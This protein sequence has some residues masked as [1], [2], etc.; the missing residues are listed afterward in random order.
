MWE[1]IIRIME[2][3]L[4]STESKSGS[5]AS[6]SGATAKES[7][8]ATVA[9]S[10]SEE[11]FPLEWFGFREIYVQYIAGK[12]HALTE[13]GAFLYTH[14]DRHEFR[15]IDGTGLARSVGL[16]NHDVLLSINNLRQGVINVDPLSIL[17]CLTDVGT[18][19]GLVVERNGK[20]IWLFAFHL[21]EEGNRPVVQ[22]IFHHRFH[23]VDIFR[24]PLVGVVLPPKSS[25]KEIP[26]YAYDNSI[27]VEL[28]LK[29]SGRF[30]EIDTGKATFIVKKNILTLNR[31]K[32][33]YN[34]EGKGTPVVISTSTTTF[35][36]D[37]DSD[38]DP[39]I[40][41]DDGKPMCIE[42]NSDGPLEV[43]P[44]CMTKPNAKIPQNNKFFFM[45]VDLSGGTPIKAAN[46]EKD[47]YITSLPDSDNPDVWIGNL[48]ET[49]TEFT[50]SI[51]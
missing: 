19:I 32:N 47:L 33:I 35:D 30:M 50:S 4:A 8:P 13:F 37:A 26:V 39:D 3:E 7:K 42:G 43:L 36:S 25:F 14:H 22:Q 38:V 48:G 41:C 23:I 9:A 40:H 49:K 28:T 10:S 15:D 34:D 31:Y 11:K 5:Q 21:D 44:D 12:P 24:F 18:N 16:R 27:K 17:E 20:E 6:Q 29:E 45:D 1:S 2:A 51:V 46:T